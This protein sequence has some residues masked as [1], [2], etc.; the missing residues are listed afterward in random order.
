MRLIF[1]RI[2]FKKKGWNFEKF[3]LYLS[4]LKNNR[5]LK[6]LLSI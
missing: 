4:I 1:E 2:F 3:I 6:I 5:S